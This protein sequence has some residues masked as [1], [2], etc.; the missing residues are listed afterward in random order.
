[1]NKVIFLICMFLS[2]FHVEILHAEEN[3]KNQTIL[4]AELLSKYVVKHSLNIENFK[5]KY[6]ISDSSQINNQLQ[7]LQKY[8][9]VLQKIQEKRI[10]G[11]VAKKSMHDILKNIKIIN[12]QL[13]YSFI[14]EKK[15]YEL[16]L[17]KKKKWYASA[18]KKLSKQL[19]T[20]NI[21]IAK[22]ILQNKSNLSSREKRIKN[23]L[24]ILN[25]ESKKLSTIES[26][27]FETEEE[28]KNYFVQIL[29]KVR[30]EMIA[31]KKTLKNK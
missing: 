21:K 12:S 19:D 8:Q 18:G 31:L 4:Q 20:I 2:L 1:M 11:E 22:K 17:E 7:K 6:N 9:L 23:H 30:T 10:T 26:K 24:I 27:T 28:L 5:K 16:R 29:K 25:Q 15:N 14:E 13:K 3:N